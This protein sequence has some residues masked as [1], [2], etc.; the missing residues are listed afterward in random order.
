MATITGSP[1]ASKPD[2]RPR[3]LWTQAED[4][5]LRKRAEILCTA[6]PE[7]SLQC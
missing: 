6:V 4:E 5:I 2:S 7:I 1:T 3:K